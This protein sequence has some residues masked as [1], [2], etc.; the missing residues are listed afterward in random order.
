VN[1]G[2]VVKTGALWLLAALL[3]T[4]IHPGRYEAGRSRDPVATVK[5]NQSALARILGEFR[6]GLSDMLFIKTERYLHSGVGYVPHL[7]E[8]LLS[9]EGTGEAVEHHLE[10]MHPG[11][12]ESAPE[13]EDR[14]HH[15]EEVETLVP[16]ARRDYRGWI[17]DMQREV[18]PWLDP[19]KPHQHTDGRELIPW[20][21]MM[22]LSDPG[23]V[24]GYVLGAFWV[25]RVDP[26]AALEFI[27]EG[28]R[29][30]PEAFQIHLSKGFLLMRKARALHPGVSLDTPHPDQMDLLLEAKRWFQSAAARISRVRPPEPAE[31]DITDHPDWNTYQESDALAAITLSLAFE[32]RYGNPEKL[33]TLRNEYKTIMPNHPRLR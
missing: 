6:T 27:E 20:F 28:L 22:V 2:V 25:E 9:V 26:D 33:Q 19:S 12:E 21:R 16:T 3:S 13:E 11:Q 7:T 14:F 24:R 23:Y 4:G 15:E 30:N 5:M 32:K 8:N 10:E 1:R 31:G 18:K 29:H 17:G